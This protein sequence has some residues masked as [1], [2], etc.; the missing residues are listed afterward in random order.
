MNKEQLDLTL[1]LA[2]DEGISLREST[3]EALQELTNPH[4]TVTL[5]GCFQVGKSTLLNKVMLGSDMLLT[6][7]KGLP[8][9]AIPTKL[10]YGERK[11]LTIVYRDENIPAQ[12]YYDSEITD[13][14]LRSLTTASA[15]NERLE[16]AEKIKYIQLA[17]PVEALR[18]YTFFDTPGVDDPNQDLIKRTTATVLPESDLVVL[19]VSSSHT[20]TQENLNFLKSAVFNQGMSRVIVLASYNPKFYQEAE[21]RAMILANIKAQLSQIGR[22]YVPVYSY[23]YDIDA[24]GDILRGESEIMS[25]LLSFIEENKVQAKID[26]A[27]YCL[28]GD[29]IAHIEQ[30]K[31]QI[32]VNGKS[33]VELKN[34]ERKIND[35]AFDLD[36]EYQKLQ[37]YLY[38][39]FGQVSSSALAELRSQMF[40]G[41]FS[42]L[43]KFG[44]K[45][46]TCNDLTAVKE[47]VDSA[48]AEITPE[49][50]DVV[51][52]CATSV[53]EK[54]YA[55]LA[56]CSEKIDNVA[57]R[58]VISTQFSPS[59]NTGWGGK[60]N[61][62]FLKVIMAGGALVITGGILPAIAVLLGDKIPFIKNLM[63][64]VFLKHLVVKTISGSF[65]DSLEVVLKDIQF[66]LD[67]AKVN[68]TEGLKTAFADIY[69]ERIAPYQSAITATEKQIL[70]DDQIAEKTK[71]INLLT[72]ALSNINI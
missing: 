6:E 13:E 36:N 70:S 55:L 67:N 23:T 50:E 44:N 62:T 49:V 37:N 69:A 38:H 58:I 8:T 40:D 41:D 60:I 2:V 52:Q 9:T 4:Y 14:L 26:K 64:Q 48:V 68:V 51:A 46:E 27:G 12:N 29:F 17:M 20:L 10:V 21:D 53:E 16:L 59:I 5:A 34:L 19:V 22:E 28:A 47:R 61:P 43:A 18:N 35:A 56:E 71:K 57:N 1:K 24:D 66:Q 11:C 7:G 25:T 32:E 54:V 3:K 42:L 72:N 31:A 65:K 30:L 15:E 39:E 45:F 33:E 63:P